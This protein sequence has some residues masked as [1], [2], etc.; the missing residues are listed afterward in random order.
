MLYTLATHSM[1]QKSAILTSI[2]SLMCCGRLEPFKAAEA[3]DAERVEAQLMRGARNTA[4]TR[5]GESRNA[6]RRL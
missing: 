4:H 3:A 1:N 6:I 5:L 2:A